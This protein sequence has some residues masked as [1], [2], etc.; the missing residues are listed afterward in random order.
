VTTHGICSGF[1]DRTIH[2][3]LAVDLREVASRIRIEDATLR[4]YER[5]DL[6]EP[7]RAVV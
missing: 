3:N 6:L 2:R 1:T 5:H 4:A 7:R